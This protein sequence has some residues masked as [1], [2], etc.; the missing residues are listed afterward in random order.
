MKKRLDTRIQERH[1]VRPLLFASRQHAPEPFQP[2]VAPVAPRALRHLSVDHHLANRLF[3]QVVRRRKVRFDETKIL[4]PPVPQPL[5]DVGRVL[6]FRDRA[7]RRLQDAFPMS[8]HF[9][10]PR[11]IR[12]TIPLMN[13]REHFANPFQQSPAVTGD[14]LV[15][16]FGKKLHLADQVRAC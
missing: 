13:R 16:A 4:P 1:H 15:L 2:A 6:V 3:S 12:P 7:P 10:L 5:R 9:P 11:R 14:Q 8:L